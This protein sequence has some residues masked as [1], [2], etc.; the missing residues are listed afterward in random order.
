[1][2]KNTTIRLPPKE[3]YTYMEYPSQQGPNHQEGLKRER[4]K[5]VKRSLDHEKALNQENQAGADEEEKETNQEGAQK[6]GKAQ[7]QT[8]VN[9]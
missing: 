7:N 1:M 6:Q 4:V 3:G 2:H 5:K 9:C 8:R